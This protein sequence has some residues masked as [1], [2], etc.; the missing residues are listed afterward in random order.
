[1]DKYTIHH[2]D[3]TISHY[4]REELI[5]NAKQQ[6]RDGVKPLY[7]FWDYK[8]NEAI[9]PAGWLVCS[10][11]QDGAIVVYPVQGDEERLGIVRGWQGEFA[12]I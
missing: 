2:H 8:R 6:K 5:E 3:G 4:T 10:T 11:Y 7:S 9:T 1:M 12:M